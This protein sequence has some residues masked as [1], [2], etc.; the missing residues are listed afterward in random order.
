MSSTHGVEIPHPNP[1][2]WGRG[3]KTLMLRLLSLAQFGRGGW[4]VRAIEL[5]LSRGSVA[6]GGVMARS[7][8]WLHASLDQE[9]GEGVLTCFVSQSGL[10]Y[11]LG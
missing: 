10:G 11:R 5:T 8:A 4:G 9:G 3:A 7:G 6:G 1:A 2:P